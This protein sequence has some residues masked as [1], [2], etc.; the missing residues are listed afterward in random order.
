ME[1]N[2]NNFT[3]LSRE[4]QLFQ[5]TNKTLEI[6]IEHL[7]TLPLLENNILKYIII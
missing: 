2:E 4:N 1:I 5:A 6:W 7:S 3:S